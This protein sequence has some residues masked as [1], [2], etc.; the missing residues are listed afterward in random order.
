[1]NLIVSNLPG[2]SEAWGRAVDQRLSKLDASIDK[3]IQQADNSNRF[4]SGQFTALQNQAQE[5]AGRKLL[6]RSLPNMS[7]TGSAVVPPFPSTTQDVSFPTLERE[8]YC[9][10]EIYATRT[11]PPSD[12]GRGVLQIIY[13]GQVISEILSQTM[14]DLSASPRVGRYSAVVN[15][16]SKEFSNTT[17][18][19]RLVREGYTSGTSTVTL[20]NIQAYFT[21]MQPPFN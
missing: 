15:V 16:M 10:L 6:I 1:M 20:T 18:Q 19:L 9:K 4:L 17:F 7:V 14:T 3:T 21:L 2:D 8:R 13:D 5:L 11:Y 12:P